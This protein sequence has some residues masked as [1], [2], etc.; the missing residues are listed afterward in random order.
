[1]DKQMMG[2][3]HMNGQANDG[4]KHMNG[5]ANDGKKAYEWTSK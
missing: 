4:K 2:K 3:K 5:Q 1:M